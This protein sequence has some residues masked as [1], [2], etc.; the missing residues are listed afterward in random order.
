M[1][2]ALQE[3][4]EPESAGSPGQKN[5]LT[6]EEKAKKMQKEQA[7]LAQVCN[8]T[9]HKATL[10]SDKKTESERTGRESRRTGERAY[11]K[12]QYFR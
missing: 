10:M 1:K 5:K 4:D 7:V 3:E 6:P 12:A 11:P 8:P 9:S 2:T